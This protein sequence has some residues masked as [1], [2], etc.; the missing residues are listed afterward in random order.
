[1]EQQRRLPPT[2]VLTHVR[3]ATLIFETVTAMILGSFHP[4]PFTQQYS[5]AVS[6]EH[7]DAFLQSMTRFGQQP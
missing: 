3:S 2:A 5:L 4:I 6:L 7:L 1:M